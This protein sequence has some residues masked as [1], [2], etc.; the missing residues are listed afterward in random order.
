[1]SSDFVALTSATH[2]V[3]LFPLSELTVARWIA[4]ARWFTGQSGGTSDS[5]VNYSG[6]RLRFLES[7]WFNPVRA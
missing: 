7:G 6:A 5:P 1:V 2:Y 4:L 3:A